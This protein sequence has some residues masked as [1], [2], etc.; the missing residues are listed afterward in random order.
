MGSGNRGPVAAILLAA[1][2]GD[3]G[4]GTRTLLPVSEA[5]PI[6]RAIEALLP[7]SVSE[8]VVV[9]GPTAVTLG[10]Q[11][12]RK[13]LTVKKHREWKKGWRSGL[14]AGLR[15]VSPDATAVL[16]ATPDTARLTTAVLDRLV[17]LWQKSG[18]G[19]VVSTL[20]GRRRLPAVLDLRYREE[21]GALR[22]ESGLEEIWDRHGDDVA[23]ADLERPTPTLGTP[24]PGPSGGP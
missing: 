17:R 3:G 10:F 1:A 4:D 8:L 24:R 7:S 16:V 23:T 9:V 19:L 15:S 13:P 5:A 2:E 6:E 21:I 14:A 18:R 11:V 22:P 12:G 20:G